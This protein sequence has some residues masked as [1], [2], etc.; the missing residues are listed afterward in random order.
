MYSWENESSMNESHSKIIC[1]T[2]DMARH[3]VPSRVQQH[4]A[5][6]EQDFSRVLHDFIFF[7]LSADEFTR[8][9]AETINVCAVRILKTPRHHSSCDCVV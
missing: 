8:M 5:S 1:I 2:A 6:F 3:Q 4:F 7:F 9:S